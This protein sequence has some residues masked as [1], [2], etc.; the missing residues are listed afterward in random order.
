MLS[1]GRDMRT[2]V[3]L[4]SALVGLVGTTAAHAQV[5]D[6]DADRVPVVELVN[7]IGPSSSPLLNDGD[8]TKL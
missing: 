4:A 8:M 2:A 6:L 3:L 1:W 5:F 7:Q